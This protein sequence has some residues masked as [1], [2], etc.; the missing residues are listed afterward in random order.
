MFV[1]I[2]GQ[3]LILRKM[4]KEKL[5]CENKE[6]IHVSHEEN[7]FTMPNQEKERDCYKNPYLF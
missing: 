6:S 4:V 3:T 2:N 5:S 1:S 7:E